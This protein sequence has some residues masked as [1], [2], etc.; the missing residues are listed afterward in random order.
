MV[1][2][3][4][5]L[6]A[7]AIGLIPVVISRHGSPSAENSYSPAGLVGV[8]VAGT[9]A[10]SLYDRAVTAMNLRKYEEAKALFDKVLRAEPSNLE[11]VYNRGV[12]LQNLHHFRDAIADYSR[13]I[14]SR[15]K[16]AKA[17]YD[18]AICFMNLEDVNSALSDLNLVIQ[19]QPSANAYSNRAKVRAALGDAAGAT[20]DEHQAER[21]AKAH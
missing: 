11:A 2:A 6:S 20:E 16:D 15:P 10:E 5:M 18:R 8:A 1:P 12:C 19:I 14:H 3:V 7:T 21:F 9:A 4:A 17:L 13:V